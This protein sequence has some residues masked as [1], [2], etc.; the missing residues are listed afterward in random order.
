MH[1]GVTRRRVRRL[2][3]HRKSSEKVKGA[4]LSWRKAQIQRTATT[5]HLFMVWQR[6]CNISNAKRS[7][8]AIS[9]E[10]KVPTRGGGI[11]I[12]D[13]PWG[14]QNNTTKESLHKKGHFHLSGLAEFFTFTF[15]FF[16]T[17]DSQ[18][19]PQRKLDNCW[20]NFGWGEHKYRLGGNRGSLSG[21]YSYQYHL[22]TSKH[23]EKRSHFE[24]LNK[25]Q[26]KCIVE[27]QAWLFGENL[28]SREWYQTN[29]QISLF[30]WKLQKGLLLLLYV[31]FQFSWI[32]VL[33]K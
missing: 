26:W 27:P 16:L 11:V 23:A 4:A 14:N 22:C 19:M 13:L 8:K 31:A 33:A 6:L 20:A 30:K 25:Y 32:T 15:L 18:R 3:L 12:H 2:E 10:G 7:F 17:L 5:A 29:F 9:R 28:G 1:Q 21:P 24:F